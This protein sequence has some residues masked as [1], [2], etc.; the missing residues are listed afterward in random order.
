MSIKN[1]DV[2]LN[3]EGSLGYIDFTVGL[4]NGQGSGDVILRLESGDIAA[5]TLNGST[6]P[7]VITTDA[8][9]TF[10]KL[11]HNGTSFVPSSDANLGD[12]IVLS[13]IK[14]LYPTQDYDPASKIYVDNTTIASVP[15]ATDN[16]LPIFSSGELVDSGIASADLVLYTDLHQPVSIWANAT[17][18]TAIFQDFE[19]A[20][21]SLLGRATGDLLNIELSV[22]Q[23]IG[24][25]GNDLQQI[26]MLEEW[27][28]VSE[29]LTSGVDGQK[30]AD[31][32]F[33]YMRGNGTVHKVRNHQPVVELDMTN[34]Q[35]ATPNCILTTASTGDLLLM[36]YTNLEAGSRIESVNNTGGTVTIDAFGT[37]TIDGVITYDLLDNT[38]VILEYDGTEWKKIV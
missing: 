3:R 17:T 12:G 36:S 20:T 33:V 4:D 8:A 26:D 10:Q 6:I 2:R 5:N 7:S 38:R 22:D 9:V 28:T 24:R 23:T 30:A 29:L 1:K 19:F 34:D 15:T 35:A 18:S 13:N 25:F 14:V 31:D 21:N 37:E 27:I 32:F 16:N 11:Q